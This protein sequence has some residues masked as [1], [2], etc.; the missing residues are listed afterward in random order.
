MALITVPPANTGDTITQEFLNSRYSEIVDEINGNIDDQNIKD[1]A[2]IPAK[3]ASSSVTTVKIADSAVTNAKL[4][5]AAGELGGAWQSWVPTWTNL[6]IGNG[7]VTAKYN[8][9]GKHI[10]FVITV[11]L[12]TTSVLGTSPTFTLP[13]TA[14]GI[15]TYPASVLGELPI[16]R[17]HLLDAGVVNYDG[18]VFM[19]SA[20]T[21]K[22]I[23]Y[24]AGGTYLNAA[25]VS[26]GVPFSWGN[27]DSMAGFGIYEA[28]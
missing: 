11:V 27:A 22:F 23:A 9:I 8:Q 12:G 21:A 20:T 26:S 4:S 13:V 28:A 18:S 10:V 7:T 2:I 17:A 14:A 3:L 25:N 15:T 6:T 5:T 16:G 19:V 1:A 24:A